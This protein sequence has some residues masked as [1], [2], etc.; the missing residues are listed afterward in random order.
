MTTSTNHPGP[1]PNA[2]ALYQALLAEQPPIPRGVARRQ[3]RRA[4]LAQTQERLEVIAS[5]K[6]TEKVTEER[7]VSESP[8]RGQPEKASDGERGAQKTRVRKSTNKAKSRKGKTSK[9]STSGGGE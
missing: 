9:P 1:S 8:V 2:Q 7:A 6:P 5:D 4:H 3:R